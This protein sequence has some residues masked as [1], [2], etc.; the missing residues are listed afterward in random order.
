MPDAFHCCDNRVTLLR[1]IA[2]DRDGSQQIA[3]DCDGSRRIAVPGYAGSESALSV[4][5]GL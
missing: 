3:A 4:R 2:T 1:R 5:T